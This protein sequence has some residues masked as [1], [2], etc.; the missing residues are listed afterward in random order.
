MNKKEKHMARVIGEYILV[1]LI[2]EEPADKTPGGIYIPITSQ[3]VKS[4]TRKCVV[5]Q[6]GEEVFSEK[7]ESFKV[8]DT[9]IIYYQAGLECKGVG[10]F[11]RLENVY[12]VDD[13]IEE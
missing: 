11:I 2:K 13:T 5:K 3:E 12:A 10:A 7:K 4:K 8:G 6:I 9:L 1:D